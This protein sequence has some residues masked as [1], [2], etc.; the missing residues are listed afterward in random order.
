MKNFRVR[1]I[2]TTRKEEIDPH[3]QRFF[4]MHQARWLAEGRLGSFYGSK[5]RNF[6]RD[7]SIGFLER[8]WLRFYHLEVDRVLRA[9]QFGFTFRG[10]LHSLQDA[11]DHEFQPVGVGGLGVV[12]R[13]MAIKESISEG[14]KAYDF[15]GGVEEFKTRWNTRSHY[16]QQVTIGAPGLKGAVAFS[17][18]VDVLKAKDWGREQMPKW[19]LNARRHVTV[20]RRSRHPAE[21][22]VSTAEDRG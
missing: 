6:Y 10:V 1:L 18:P 4:A 3:L 14:L 12:L 13:A 5:K 16:V 11:F 8:G 21:A 17:V 2:R 7:L 9:S 19:L 15:L 20:W 22:A